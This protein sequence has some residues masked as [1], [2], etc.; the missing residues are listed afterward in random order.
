MSYNIAFSFE[1]QDMICYNIF[2]TEDVF[3]A[4]TFY[5]NESKIQIF[6]IFSEQ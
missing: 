1:K 3:M 6:R 2:E 5:Y 4:V